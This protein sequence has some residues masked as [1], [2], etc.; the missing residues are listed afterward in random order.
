VLGE[1]PVG[2]DVTTEE[3]SGVCL[4]ESEVDISVTETRLDDD[5]D[6]E[7]CLVSEDLEFPNVL[8]IV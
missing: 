8:C 4:D 3:T 2:Y 6:S 1:N 7:L 5:M